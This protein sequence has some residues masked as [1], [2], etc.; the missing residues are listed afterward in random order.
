MY[1]RAL[2]GRKKAG[3]KLAVTQKLTK[4]VKAAGRQVNKETKFFDTDLHRF[5]LTRSLNNIPAGLRGTCLVGNS[6]SPFR[7]SRGMG[8][9]VAHF[10]QTISSS[11][12]G[13]K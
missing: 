4:V 3:E 1:L 2:R 9:V 11:I 10:E 12:S 5:T 7:N 8:N 13:S 6:Y